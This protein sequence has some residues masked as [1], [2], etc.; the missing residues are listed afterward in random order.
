[1]EVIDGS[2]D[3]MRYLLSSLLGDFEV[4]GLEVVEEVATFE[5]LHDNVDVVGVLKNIV[6][7]DDV[8][9]LAN[10]QHFDL[11]FEQL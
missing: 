5:I 1:M 7:S 2:G 11:S 8:W 3:L 4:L 9:M 6:E 10:L